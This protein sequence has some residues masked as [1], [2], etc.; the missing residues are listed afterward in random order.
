MPLG[1][2]GNSSAL[3]LALGYCTFLFCFPSLT[4]TF[5]IVSSIPS[6]HCGQLAR[7]LCTRRCLTL[8][9]PPRGHYGRLFREA[10]CPSVEELLSPV[11]GAEHAC[12]PL[13]VPHLYFWLS[14]PEDSIRGVHCPFRWSSL[15]GMEMETPS[16]SRVTHAAHG[17]H[18][19]WS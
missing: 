19:S 17:K 1:W 2:R 5:E 6:W 13:A 15:A 4:Q 9:L 16:N 18:T 8:I 10:M 11:P 14:A 12:L 7:A 3:L